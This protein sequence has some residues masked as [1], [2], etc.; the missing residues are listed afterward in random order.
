MRKI[1]SLYDLELAI[2]ENEGVQTFEELEFGPL[3]RHPLVL[4]YFQVSPDI[5]EAFRIRS[6]EL[7]THLHEFLCAHPYKEVKVDK[8]L[9]YIAEKRSLP[10]KEK[11]TVRIQ[12]LG[13]VFLNLRCIHDNEF[14]KFD[15]SPHICFEEYFC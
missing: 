1:T 6:E 2:C 14:I 7:V 4:H 13:Y 12:S 10:C 3:V 11:L 9:D 8:F 5:K 15:V